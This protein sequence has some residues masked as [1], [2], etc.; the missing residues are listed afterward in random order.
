[1]KRKPEL[2]D[3]R[4]DIYNVIE[5]A[6]KPL[7]VKNILD[8]LEAPPNMSTVYRALDFMEKQGLIQSIAFFDGTRFYFSA[9][10]HTHFILCNECHEIREFEHCTAAMMQEA[11]AESFHYTITDHVLYFKGVCEDCRKVLEK[12]ARFS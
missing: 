5:V 1:M 6:E 12:K 2:T 9:R 10:K 11:V 3:L 8:V 7:S 4:K